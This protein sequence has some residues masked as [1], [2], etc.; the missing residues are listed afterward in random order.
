M[1]DEVATLLQVEVAAPPPP[2]RWIVATEPAFDWRPSVLTIGVKLNA[3][4]RSPLERRGK[5]VPAASLDE[6]LAHMRDARW[7]AVIV[8]PGLREES[9]GLR[10][11]RAMK[12]P[13]RADDLSLRVIALRD[14]YERVPFI[15][16]PLPD[17]FEFALFRSA[18]SWFLGDS[19]TT[20]LS[21]AV[22]RSL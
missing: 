3:R 2:G 15:V 16:A 10:F 20:P 12:L 8:A 6:G 4:D 5:I 18:K 19:R 7:D 13:V 9:D 17:D 14:R 22:L 11:V 1:H 21:Y